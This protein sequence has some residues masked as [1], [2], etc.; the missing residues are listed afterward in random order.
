MASIGTPKSKLVNGKR[1]N[2]STGQEMASSVSKD[3]SDVVRTKTNPT[4]RTVNL[5]GGKV[6]NEA[7]SLDYGVD[8]ARTNEI[9]KENNITPNDPASLAPA[10]PVAPTAPISQQAKSIT[11]ADI[12]TPK[13]SEY[14]QALEQIKAS[15]VPAPQEGGVARGAVQAALPP[16][17]APL[18]PAVDN[19]FNTNPIVQQST[20]DLVDF[21]SPPS[22]RK[23]LEKSMKS[24]V[25]SQKE[26]AGLKLELM[27]VKR[28]MEGSDQDIRD[29][30][31]KA[32]GFA[33]ESQVQ[34][35]TIGRNRTLLKK[36]NMITDQLSYLQDVIQSDMTMYGFQKDMAQTEFQQRSFLLNYKQQNDQFIYKA[37]QDAVARNLELLGPDGLLAAAG[38]D[39]VKISRIE[40]TLG[41]VAGG[42]QTAATAAAAAKARQL[43]SQ[44]LDLEAKRFGL[45]TARQEAPLDLQLK[46]AQISAANRSNQGGGG[47]DG[48]GDILKMLQINQ[49]QNTLTQ[50]T[51]VQ[52]TSAGYADRVKNSNEIIN[53]LGNT[54]AK[55]NPFT[56]GVQSRV[57]NFLKT[58]TM[59]QFEQAQRD[60]INAVLRRESGAAISES[61]FD[62]AR[63]QYFPAPGDKPETI[64]QKANNRQQIISNINREAGPAGN[65]T[66]GP[67]NPNDNS[68]PLGLF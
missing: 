30:V 25:S 35:L 24:I 44:Q 5:P 17:P 12:T 43:E 26:S 61:E 32:G 68:D 1:I 47:G 4:G 45:E 54:I 42:L 7:D 67:T 62:N 27:D 37:N 40:R 38:G 34:A 21:L 51:D 6:L 14:Q 13:P 22:I 11:A 16:A 57:P 56:Y 2:I 58:G 15:G 3:Q 18:P 49:L 55:Y 53:K 64:S 33:T 59:Q 23:E 31:E 9:L 41:L 60:F 39:P 8:D 50:G 46:K 28:V 52:R 10:G 48:L 19:F 65:Q 36:A 66:Y 29:E 20:Q 63:Q